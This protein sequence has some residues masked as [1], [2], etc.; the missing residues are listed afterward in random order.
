[1][2]I[3]VVTYTRVDGA[4]VVTLSYISTFILAKPTIKVSPSVIKTEEGQSVK[5]R[6]VVTGSPSPKITWRRNNGSLPV[7]ASVLNSSNTLVIRNVKKDDGGIYSC[8]ATNKKGTVRASSS[9]RVAERL[10]LDS[11][12]NNQKTV[13]VVAS[14]VFTA[15]C[16]YKGGM[17][18][19]TIRWG[20]YGGRLP[21]KVT[22]KFSNKI[23]VISNISKE[24]AGKF[25]CNVSS[26]I[27]K[28]SLE[29]QLHVFH[30]Q[31][32]TQLKNAGQ[33]KSGYYKIDPDGVSGEAPVS[34]YCNMEE[35]TGAGVTEIPH[36]S[37][38]RTLV[39][40]CES[41][42]CYK[43]D[44]KYLISLKQIKALTMLSKSCEQT[45]KYECYGSLLNLNSSPF[46][47]MKSINNK[48]LLYWGDT[49]YSNRGCA[50][51]VTNTCADK[52]KKCNCD[53]NDLVWRE[54]GGVLRHKEDLPILQLRF[55]DTGHRGE[56]GYHTL[57]KLKCYGWNIDPVLKL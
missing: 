40:G 28:F 57:G 18:P 6:C 5:V 43:R 8:I 56:K 37:E 42:G 15:Y 51:G 34:V 45:I 39:E 50:C 49:P 19:V 48:Q 12:N 25:Y 30:A 54:D 41:N 23:M 32:C 17:P 22:F 7:G 11:P 35:K 31:S 33:T 4:L 36:D 24:D 3:I 14:G 52:S 9:L 38:A 29:F 2:I 26:L 53:V 10:F 27:S 20:K 21:S 44:V 46:G 16:L 1:M 47:W 55:G 13:S